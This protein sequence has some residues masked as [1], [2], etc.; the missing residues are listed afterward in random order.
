MCLGKIGKEHKE[1]DTFSSYLILDASKGKIAQCKGVVECTKLVLRLLK[2][3]VSKDWTQ[4]KI[5]SL[6]FS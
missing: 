5:L 2:A 4:I 6:L 1:I 3:L